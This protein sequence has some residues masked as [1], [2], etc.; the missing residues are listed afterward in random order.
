MSSGPNLADILRCSGQ[1]SR[2]FAVPLLYQALWCRKWEGKERGGED[3]VI[4]LQGCL[5]RRENHGAQQNAAEQMLPLEAPLEPGTGI[6]PV[7]EP[8]PGEWN[9]AQVPPGGLPTN[10][11]APKAGSSP[12]ENN[13]STPRGTA[14]PVRERK[15]SI[16]GRGAAVP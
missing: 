13:V 2:L 10:C 15:E 16:G 9:D 3:L 14:S 4:V 1:S 7:S 8:V 6:F 5:R 11:K 12:V